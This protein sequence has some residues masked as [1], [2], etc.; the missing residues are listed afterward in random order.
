MVDSYLE[1][2]LAGWRV[3]LGLVQL[4][5]RSWL[6]NEMKAR[7]LGEMKPETL[8]DSTLGAPL[9]EPVLETP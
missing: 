2:N 3:E 4:L 8:L 9:S 7:L 6:E 1:P 5:E